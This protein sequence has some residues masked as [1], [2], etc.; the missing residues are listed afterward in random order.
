VPVRVAGLLDGLP[1]YTPVLHLHG[2]VGWFVRDGSVYEANVRRYQ[3]DFGSPLVM[4]PDPDK[5]YDQDGIIIAMWQEFS[6]ALAAVRT[7]PK[8]SGYP[9]APVRMT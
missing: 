3:A 1:R 7:V 5:A 9:P 6:N 8:P 4:L 2:R